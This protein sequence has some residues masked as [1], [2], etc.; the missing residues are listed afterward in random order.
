MLF[1]LS[2]CSGGEVNATDPSAERLQTICTL[3]FK[4]DDGT[5]QTELRAEE[6]LELYTN[7]RFLA[8]SDENFSELKLAAS[9]YY[10]SFQ[11]LLAIENSGQ[12]G[13]VKMDLTD[14]LSAR[15]FI[16]STCSELP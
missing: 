15:D 9:D 16:S 5:Q 12:T 8:Q 4:V 2:A 6:A 1:S 3:F 11:E 10:A 14:Y 13:L 7:A